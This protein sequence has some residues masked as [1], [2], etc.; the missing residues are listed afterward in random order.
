M[1]WLF[2]IVVIIAA[3]VVALVV[4][5]S[6]KFYTHRYRLSVAAEANGSTH[7][8]SSVIEVTWIKQ[9]QNLPT[10]VPDFVATVRGTAAVVV[11][12]DGRV[13]VALLGPADPLD[14]P[15]PAEFRAMQ[16]Y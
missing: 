5:G 9:S 13:V 8:G 12:G 7:I 10:R 6:N 15:T 16:A 14:V 1:K 11:R 2:A 4:F 3:T